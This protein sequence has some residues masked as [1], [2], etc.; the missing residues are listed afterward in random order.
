MMNKLRLSVDFEISKESVHELF[1]SLK[2]RRGLNRNF[3]ES[4]E[5][6]ALSPDINNFWQVANTITSLAQDLNDKNRLKYERLAGS[7]LNLDFP[8]L[9]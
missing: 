5:G 3:I 7:L 6:H 9:D 1:S 2:Q 4:V 8:K